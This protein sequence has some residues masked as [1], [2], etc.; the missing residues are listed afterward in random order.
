MLFTIIDEVRFGEVAQAPPQLKAKPRRRS[1][2]DTGS[3]PQSQPLH[4]T[5]SKRVVLGLK[6]KLDLELERERAISVYRQRKKAALVK[7]TQIV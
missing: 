3:C 6:R 2:L 1:K 7:R 5:T 4:Q